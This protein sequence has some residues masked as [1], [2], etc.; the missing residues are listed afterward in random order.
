M[1]AALGM[2]SRL[3]LKNGDREVALAARVAQARHER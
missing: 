3:S 1:I 2:L